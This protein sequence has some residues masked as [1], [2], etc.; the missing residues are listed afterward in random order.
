[1]QRSFYCHIYIIFIS[2]YSLNL[3]VSYL[4]LKSTPIN[5]KDEFSMTTTFE[6]VLMLV[7]NSLK[8]LPSVMSHGTPPKNTLFE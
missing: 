2:I 7:A 1:M 6:T 5:M 4:C 8:I 3:F